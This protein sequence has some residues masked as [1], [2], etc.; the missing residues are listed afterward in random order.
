M[1]QL[2]ILSLVGGNSLKDVVKRCLQQVFTKSI[3]SGFVFQGGSNTRKRSF[4]K[5]KLK[6]MIFAAVSLHS[7]ELKLER[8][9]ESAMKAACQ[10]F[11]KNA[12][13]SKDER[14]KRA[15]AKKGDTGQVLPN[16]DAADLSELASS[17]SAS[18][19]VAS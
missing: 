8:P 2:G 10:N 9:T 16:R 1:S 4:D 14:L 12:A 7:D 17:E 15:L 18:D 6:E 13:D 3:A 19:Q 5:M 11:F